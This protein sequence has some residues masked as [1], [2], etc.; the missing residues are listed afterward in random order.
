MIKVA[1]YYDDDGHK[2]WVGHTSQR[3]AIT[4]RSPGDEFKDWVTGWVW[5]VEFATGP[6]VQVRRELPEC[7]KIDPDDYTL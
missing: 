4:A 6:W 3:E 5:R 2:R 1:L 7:R